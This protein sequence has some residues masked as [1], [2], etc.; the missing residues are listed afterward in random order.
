MMPRTVPKTVAKEVQATNKKTAKDHV[1]RMK[2]GSLSK[3]K[4][5]GSKAAIKVD[6]RKW[7]DGGASNGRRREAGRGRGRCDG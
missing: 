6:E 4:A 1:Q 3:E 2:F 5:R 7:R